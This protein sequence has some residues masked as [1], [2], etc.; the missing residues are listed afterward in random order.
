MFHCITSSQI[1]RD[2]WHQALLHWVRRVSPCVLNQIACAT[3]KLP[4]LEE[5]PTGCL[6]EFTGS[7]F[8]N[9]PEADL[10]AG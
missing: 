2:G 3:V 10:L 5:K 8:R 7:S 4:V 1:V 6:E 9:S